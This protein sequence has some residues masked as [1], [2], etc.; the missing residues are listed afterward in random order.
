MKS[1]FARANARK[2]LDPPCIKSWI[3]PWTCQAL[4]SDIQF[5]KIRY[6]SEDLYSCSIYSCSVFTSAC[7]ANNPKSG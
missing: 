4:P 3:R 6:C 2:I 5:V 7:T 1:S